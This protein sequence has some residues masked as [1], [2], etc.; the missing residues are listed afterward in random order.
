M[1]F[2]RTLCTDQHKV[3]RDSEMEEIESMLFK[4]SYRKKKKNI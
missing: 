1:D 2:I 4:I 3:V